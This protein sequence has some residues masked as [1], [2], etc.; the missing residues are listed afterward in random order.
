MSTGIPNIC[1]EEKLGD[2]FV[3]T[4][5]FGVIGGLP[6]MGLD[7]GSAYNPR[8]ILDQPYQFDFYDGGGLDIAF[9]SFAQSMRRGTSTLRASATV[10]TAAAGS[11]ISRRTPSASS[12]WAR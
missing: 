10:R 2:A 8:A 9:L 6:A 1:A 4:V 7:F 5:E 3:L 11:S 12:S